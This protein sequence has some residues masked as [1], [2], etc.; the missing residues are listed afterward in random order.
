M[1]LVEAPVALHWDPVAVGG[2]QGEVGGHD[3][4]AQHR[5]EELLG[6]DTGLLEELTAVDGLS[7]ALV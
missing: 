4:A 1:T 5:G 7:A 6:E 2:V 3:G